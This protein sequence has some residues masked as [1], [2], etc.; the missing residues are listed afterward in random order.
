MRKS[1]ADEALE[2]ARLSHK[3][4][5]R[6]MRSE[7]TLASKLKAISEQDMVSESIGKKLLEAADA[8]QSR[9]RQLG[10][11]LDSARIL[12]ATGGRGESWWQGVARRMRALPEEKVRGDLLPPPHA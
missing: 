8:A 7:L 9:A 1:T 5:E 11:M 2:T 3:I 12:L 10:D 4:L 6:A